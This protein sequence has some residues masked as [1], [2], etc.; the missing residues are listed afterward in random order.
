M[1][2]VVNADIL[3][4]ERISMAQSRS[5]A[6]NADPIA[7]VKLEEA[8]TYLAKRHRVTPAIV[9]EIVRR[10]DSSERAA[11]EREINKGKTRR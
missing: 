6:E 8:I 2:R 3:R 1:R 9:R 10:P 11:V 4:R 7:A 5:T